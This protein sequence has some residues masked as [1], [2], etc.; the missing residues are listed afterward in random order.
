MFYKPFISP[1]Q[2]PLQPWLLINAKVTQWLNHLSRSCVKIESMF[3]LNNH[4]RLFKASPYTSHTQTKIE[5]HR[6]YIVDG[7]ASINHYQHRHLRPFSKPSLCSSRRSWASIFPA[8]TPVSSRLRAREDHDYGK[9]RD[10]VSWHRKTTIT[11]K[12]EMQ[13]PG[14]GRPRLRQ[15]LRCS[16]LAREDHDYGED[17]DAVSWQRKTTITAKTEMQSPDKVR[18]QLR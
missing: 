10:A 1:L 8:T 16:L 3:N 4:Y 15:S 2:S 6:F 14:T 17:W 13:S 11:V 9:D 18:P 5:G 12:T 7:T